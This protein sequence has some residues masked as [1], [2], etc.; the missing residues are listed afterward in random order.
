MNH[1]SSSAEMTLSSLEME[2]SRRTLQ[3]DMKSAPTS[4]SYIEGILSSVPS[5]KMSTFAASM[6]FVTTMVGAGVLAFPALFKKAGCILAPALL[7]GIGWI[8]QE[9]G[10]IV[11]SSLEKVEQRAHLGN[12]VWSFGK[13]PQSLEDLGEVAFGKSGK[14]CIGMITNFT[15]LMLCGALVVLIGSSLEFV[16]YT[17]QPYRFWVLLVSAVFFVLGLLKDMSIVSKL[18]PIGVMA[19]VVYIA[20]ICCGG[21]FVV[22]ARSEA[23]LEMPKQSLFPESFKALGSVTAVMLLGF[24]FVSVVPPVRAG[25]ATPEEMPKAISLSVR[26]VTSVYMLAGGLGYYAWG[27]AVS[28][29]VLSD[30]TDP[31]TGLPL[32][33]GMVLSVAILLNLM[34]TFPILGNVVINAFEAAAGTSYSLPIRIGVVFLSIIIGLL[35]PYFLEVIGVIA[36]IGIVCMSV[37]IPIPCAWKLERNL[38]AGTR[39]KH[40][41]MMVVGMLALV[42]GTWDSI[43]DLLDALKKGGADPI[44]NFWKPMRD[45]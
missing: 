25:M 41:V 16:S 45:R 1:P 32:I 42:F 33:S 13:T 30:M 34:V 27:N 40:L 17:W 22:G 21:L 26:V 4:L 5:Q 8:T 7:L 28:G 38:S 44:A 39:R 14:F 11:N 12:E 43:E 18:S 9:I 37:F 36:A 19:S 31:V 10:L 20:C 29:N 15:L 23:G 24:F 35:C 6:N 2:G 3:S